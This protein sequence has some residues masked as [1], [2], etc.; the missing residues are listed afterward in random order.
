MVSMF[1]VGQNMEVKFT[2][3]SGWIFLYFLENYLQIYIAYSILIKYLLYA[4]W[5]SELLSSEVNA[6]SSFLDWTDAGISDET[7][8]N[9]GK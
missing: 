6:P 4:Q 7:W 2:N 5:L 3:L 8:N 9:R 1:C